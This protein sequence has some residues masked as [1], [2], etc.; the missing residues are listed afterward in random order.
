MGNMNE[1]EKIEYNKMLKETSEP[2]SSDAVLDEVRD[3]EFEIGALVF[4]KLLELN[5]YIT[6]ICFR[7]G[8]I[9]YEVSF[10]SNA[11]YK[12]IWMENFEIEKV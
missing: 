2:L 3:F 12:Q 11:E 7:L 4:I 1:Q 10:F 8:N 6:A 9:S 5:G